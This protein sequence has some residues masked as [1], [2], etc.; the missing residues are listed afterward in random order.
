MFIPLKSPQCLACV[1]LGT[2]TLTKDSWDANVN[3][4][5]V[6]ITSSVCL[7][8]AGCRALWINYL[9]KL[10]EDILHIKSLSVKQSYDQKKKK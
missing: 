8:N 1:Y 2:D 10:T 4:F 5:K 9:Q 3:P 7:F 6:A